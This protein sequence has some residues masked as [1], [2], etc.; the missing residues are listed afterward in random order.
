MPTFDRK[1]MVRVAIG[2]TLLAALALSG[3][4]RK[5]GLEAPG[6]NAGFVLSAIAKSA[7]DILPGAGA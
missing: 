1:F 4:G 5:A 3:C 2:G 6:A 7:E